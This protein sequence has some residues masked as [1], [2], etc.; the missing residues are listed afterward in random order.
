[1]RLEVLSVKA[2]CDASI[3]ALRFHTRDI[4]E[5]VISCCQLTFIEQFGAKKLCV[6][7]TEKAVKAIY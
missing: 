2:L 7:N 4:T 1:M 3:K 5:T 6:E